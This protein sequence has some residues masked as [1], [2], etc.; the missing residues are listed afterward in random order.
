MQ[1]Y[2]LSVKAINFVTKMEIEQ[3]GTHIWKHVTNI[4]MLATPGFQ[5]LLQTKRVKNRIYAL[6]VNEIDLLNS[7][8]GGAGFRPLFQQSNSCVLILDF[9]SLGG[10]LAS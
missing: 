9:I 3:E 5:Q 7:W 4:F 10:C 2:G 8:P 1:C 6:I